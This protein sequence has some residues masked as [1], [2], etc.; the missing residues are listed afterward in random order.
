MG[1]PNEMSDEELFAELIW[2]K[3]QTTQYILIDDD[4]L[5]PEIGEVICSYSELFE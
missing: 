5:D 1:I 3:L 2:D 4:I